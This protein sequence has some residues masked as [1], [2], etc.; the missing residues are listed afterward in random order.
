VAEELDQG[1]VGTIGRVTVPI[2][3]QHSGE[4]MLPVRG[5]TEAYAACAD[6]A[7][8]KNSRVVVIEQLSGRTVLV[9]PC[10]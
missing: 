7:I 8:H 3:P 2:D 9:T 10:A 5:G 4:V 1:L 6:Q